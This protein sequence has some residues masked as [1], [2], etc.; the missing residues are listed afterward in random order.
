MC[1]TR[2]KTL[3]QTTLLGIEIANFQTSLITF[4]SN[5]RNITESCVHLLCS[6]INPLPDISDLPCISAV[7]LSRFLLSILVT[8][9]VIR[10]RR[11]RI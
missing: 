3:L 11:L 9:F 2:L 6:R 1:L 5:P 7:E 10:M 8:V 4:M